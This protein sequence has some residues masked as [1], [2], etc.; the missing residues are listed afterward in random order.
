M[1]KTVRQLAE[2]IG[3][4]KQAVHQKRKSKA[5]STALQPFTS[6]IDGVVYIDVDGEKLIKQAFGINECKQ[7][8]DNKT[9][10]ID[11]YVYTVLNNTIDMLKEQLTIKD[12]QIE[13][14]STALT[15]A[16][17]SATSAQALHAGTIQQQIEDKGVHLADDKATLSTKKRKKLFN[18][19]KK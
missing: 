13:T 8:D 1:S 10:Q 17:Q 4:S 12:K 7:V 16:L 19:G 6:T 11:D 14:L 5:L 18:L 15:S 3:V 9:S 2:E